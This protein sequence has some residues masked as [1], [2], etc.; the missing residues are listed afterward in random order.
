MQTL[1]N[2]FPSDWIW[3]IF[4]SRIVK[5]C[6][7]NQ[8]S[9]NQKPGSGHGHREVQATTKPKEKK[10]FMICIAGTTELGE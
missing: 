4:T 8:T 9:P 6:Q 1:S 10:P 7:D 2:E 5:T 3:N